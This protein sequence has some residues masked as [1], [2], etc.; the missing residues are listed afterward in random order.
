MG[1]QGTM[2]NL[3][4]VF[5][6]PEK[7]AT[8]FNADLQKALATNDQLKLT[9]TFIKSFTFLLKEQKAQLLSNLV[10][11]YFSKIEDIGLLESKIS[12]PQLKQSVSLL[13]DNEFDP[14]AL[15]ICDRFG[16]S[17]EAINLLARRGKAN[18][19]FMWLSRS[20]RVDKSMLQTAVVVWEQFNGDIRNNTTLGGVLN[21]IRKF[22]PG[23]IPDH[24]HVWEVLEEFE[25]AAVLYTNQQDFENAA[26][27]YQKAELFDEASRLYE[28]LGDHER[29]SIT[30]EAAGHL[31]RALALVINPK[32][33]LTLLM[34]T[35]RFVEARKFAAGLEHAH[36]YLDLV[37]EQARDQV[38]VNIRSH[39]FMEALELADIAECEPG[40]KEEILSLGRRDF[41]AK[42]ASASSEQELQAI[43]QDR[44]K[45]EEKAGYFEEAGRLAE[46]VLGDLELASFLYEKAN[47]FNRAIDT[48]AAQASKNTSTL[49]LAELHEK[50]GN[51]SKAARLYESV[52]QYEKAFVLYESSQQFNKAIECYLKLPS[53]SQDVLIRLYSAAGEFE[54]VV[55]VYMNSGSFSD[56]E[57]ALQIATTRKLASHIRA[58]KE[59]MAEIVVGGESDLETHFTNAR[60]EILGRY[61][62]IMGVDFGTTNSVVA[63]F[64]KGSRNA[65]IVLTDRGTEFEPTY[66]GVDENNHPIFGEAARLRSLTT[67]NCVVARVKRTIGEKQFF[68][69]NGK[70]Y[71]CE[72]VIAS[73]LRQFRSNAEA[74]VQSKVETRFYELLAKHDLK[75]PVEMLQ[76][77]LHKQERAFHIES[78]VLSVPAYFNDNQKR[79][80]RDSAEIAG[81]RVLRLLHEPTAAALAYSYQKP[82]SGKLAVVDLGGGTLDISIVEIGEGVNEVHVVGGDTQ[83]GGSDID[84]VLV[85]HVIR[86]IQELWGIEVNEKDY[87]IEAA[88]LRDACENLKINL[89]MVTQYT[90]EL[91]HFLNRPKFSFTMT[92]TELEHLANPILERIRKAIE[93]TIKDYGSKLDNFLLVG[94]ATKM[95]AV[96][97][98]VAKTISAKPLTG[99]D[100][101]TVVAIGAALEGSILSGETKQLLLL[102]V[103]PYSLG[104][105]ALHEKNVTEAIDKIIEKNSTIPIKQSNIF[106][107]KEDN[108]PNVHIKVYQGESSQPHKNYFLGDFILDGIL[109]AP[110]HTPKIEVIFDIGAD[111][112]LTVTAIDKASGNKRSIRI[113]RAIVLSPQEKQTL[114]NYFAQR[115]KMF[116]DETD[117][118]SETLKINELKTS[119]DNAIKSAEQ[120]IK[121]FFERFQ[122]KVEVNPQLYQAKPE[123]ISEIQNMFVLKE[124]FL[125]GI[126]KY[127]DQLSSLLSNLQQIETSP[128]NFSDRE[129][130]IKMKDRAEALSNYRRMLQDMLKLIEKDVIAI[131]ENWIQTLDALEPN[132][133]NMTVNEVANYHLTAGRA[134]QAKEI[135]ENLASSSA[136]LT[137]ETFQL[138]LKCYVSLGMKEAYRETHKRYGNLFGS[139]YPDFSRLN[140]YLKATDE[141]VFMIQGVTETHGTVSGSGFCIAPNLIVTNRHVVEGMLRQQ[142]RIIGKNTS[143]RVDQLEVDP[144][145]DIAILSVRE[146]LKPFILG[147]FGFVEPGEQ[148]LAI[149][150]PNPSSNLHSENL[151]ISR[152]IVNSIRHIEVASERVIFIDTKIGAGMS[153]GPLINDLGEAVGIITL[154]RYSLGQ[155]EKGLFPIEDQPVALPIH[156]VRKYMMKSYS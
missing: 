126:P 148:V 35:G 32:R 88:R 114:I 137:K 152:G 6:S 66:F 44:I 58:I 138:L 125:H 128:L 144:F 45:L 81:L 107:T 85:Q 147:E 68:S 20:N 112:I 63:I 129:I 109:P 91:I 79:V 15:M 100:P 106:S 151:F 70:Q 21:N 98:L 84:A 38:E 4:K 130:N 73:F 86:N 67:A 22:S 2:K 27:C 10:L 110:A 123:Q 95:P 154:I 119:C 141:L 145:N 11:A 143:Y 102:D 80:T 54:K 62:P 113:E 61:S 7:K 30:A 77:Y 36:T 9:S 78:I 29:A 134:Y 13:E 72:E 60:K 23:S 75:F 94:N 124:Q 133:E 139:I 33:K 24:P 92:R 118:E 76:A 43:Y 71:R 117:L 5:W 108:Q 53:P 52:E 34:R 153:G 116:A 149:G 150:F 25:Q 82:Y 18:Q 93:S 87:P 65:E 12:P 37:K 99:I 127:R 56:L 104:I 26:K 57:K 48:I 122:E 42:I 155:S 105:A 89:S 121:V 55:E 19:L 50:G 59:R 103:V 142:I 69:L 51:L 115:D 1:E 17:N 8:S 97:D 31:A 14:A 41:D 120:S 131:V 28:R 16:Y 3:L 74:Y 83:L 111:C 132:L 135:L 156:L 101:G 40:K 96:R 140:T 47:L 146:S 49:R 39:D 64:N 90:M 136:G 46:E